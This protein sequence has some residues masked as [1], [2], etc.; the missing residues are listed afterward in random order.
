M[1]KACTGLLS[2]LTGVT[3][4][5]ALGGCV[6]P[7]NDRMT[8]GR[9]MRVD[10]FA[11]PDAAREIAANE[12]PRSVEPSVAGLERGNWPRT[13]ILVPVDGTD[14]TPT[15]AKRGLVAD[16]TAKQR[17]QYPTA[18]SAL[19]MTNGSEG[20]QQQEALWNHILALTDSLLIGPR[21]LVDRPWA[22]RMSPDEAYERLWRVPRA[23]PQ[24]TPEALEPFERPKPTQ[25]TP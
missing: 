24:P 3:L 5:V 12:Q 10:A 14:H 9:T 2:V 11:R 1:P 19:E 8:E 13:T 4:G 25:V 15:F 21:M 16:K 6:S 17:R 20:Q 18:E 22:A 7:T 23:G